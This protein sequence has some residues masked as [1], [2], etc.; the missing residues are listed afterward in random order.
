M[1][2]QSELP[3]VHRIAIISDSTWIANA[4]EAL[5]D[6]IYGTKVESPYPDTYLF[7]LGKIA[8]HKVL[9]GRPQHDNTQPDYVSA[10]EFALQ[11]SSVELVL[12]VGVCGAVPSTDVGEDSDTSVFLGDVIIGSDIGENE[13]FKTDEDVRQE[14]ILTDHFGSRSLGVRAFV[15]ELELRK[16]QLESDIRLPRQL[17]DQI[18]TGGQSPADS[19]KIFPSDYG[20][21]NRN[22]GYRDPEGYR[23]DYSD[24]PPVVLDEDILFESDDR[25]DSADLHPDPKRSSCEEM[26]CDAGFMV[27]R[28][29]HDHLDKKHV[30]HFGS[31]CSGRYVR[32]IEAREAITRREGVIGFESQGEGPWHCLPSIMVKGV[33]H[34]ADG[35]N[36]DSWRKY[37]AVVAAAATVR[38]LEYWGR[39]WNPDRSR[40]DLFISTFAGDL[41]GKG[42]E[43]KPERAA[44]ESLYEA[45]P[46]LLQK[47][48]IRAK[49]TDDFHR[50][51]DAV[52]LVR[53][54]R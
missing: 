53:N 17:C 32:S 19:R 36:F 40:R 54:Y 29:P 26:N 27:S 28:G 35:H 31:I 50:I 43:E 52:A 48:A 1:A 34:H 51:Q 3:P 45:L 38:L 22:P 30:I 12:L 14:K 18:W 46:G 7:G 41:L 39:G 37:A 2:S 16:E 49:A 23:L 33:A 47:F 20:H 42:F 9:L 25:Y 10:R 11:F 4:I 8:G 5:C 15:E 24:L 44:L 13:C 6:E 21:K